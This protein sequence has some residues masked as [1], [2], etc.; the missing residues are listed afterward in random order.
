[1]K[2][3]LKGITQA[4]LMMMEGEFD[5]KIKHHE[6]SI[7]EETLMNVALFA[8]DNYGT[9]DFLD[10]TKEAEAEL[11]K[12]IG[13]VLNEWVPKHVE[14]NF[15]VEESKFEVPTGMDWKDAVKL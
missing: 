9:Y 2:N 3:L 10:V 6:A 5:E 4:Q 15:W 8:E 1:M 13:K 14:V 11:A 7:A 12:A